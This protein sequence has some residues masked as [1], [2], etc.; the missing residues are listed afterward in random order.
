MVWHLL[1]SHPRLKSRRRNGSRSDERVATAAG[2]RAVFLDRDGV[3]NRAVVREAALSPRD[4][5]A[6][7]SC[8]VCPRPCAGSTTLASC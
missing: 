2:A 5:E 1:V 4:L 7:R 6:S 3:L 8:P